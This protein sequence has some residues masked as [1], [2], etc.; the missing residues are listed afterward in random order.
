MAEKIKLLIHRFNY[1]LVKVMEAGT[2]NRFNNPSL[3]FFG[4]LNPTL[5]TQYVGRL[6]T[7]TG[8][9]REPPAYC[10]NMVWLEFDLTPNPMAVLD[11]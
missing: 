5:W 4:L 2:T 3:E 7:P 10:R 6:N 9:R 11:P 8:N 1:P